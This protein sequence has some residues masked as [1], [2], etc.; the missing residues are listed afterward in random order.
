MLYSR[1]GDGDP[2]LVHA[3]H[4]FLI[5]LSTDENSLCSALG[6]RKLLAESNE[7]TKRTYMDVKQAHRWLE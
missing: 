6:A 1:G 5:K 7:R 3:N 4:S 2:W